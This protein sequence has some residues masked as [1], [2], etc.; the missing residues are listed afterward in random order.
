MASSI[1]IDQLYLVTY[2][3]AEGDMPSLQHWEFDA[4]GYMVRRDMSANDYKIQES[5]RRYK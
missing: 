4:Q 3:L 2:K 5:E 1:A